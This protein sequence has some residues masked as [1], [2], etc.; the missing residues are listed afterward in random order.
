LEKW[1]VLG[2]RQKTYKISMKHLI[3]PENKEV[4]NIKTKQKH[5]MMGHI[6]GAQEY[7]ERSPKGQLWNSL[8]NKNF[9]VI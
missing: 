1:P 4:L 6:K 5:T 7:T 9:K 8:S 3:I 2:L